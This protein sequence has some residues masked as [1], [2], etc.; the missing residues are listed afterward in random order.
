MPLLQL[1][2]AIIVLS[3]AG[4]YHVPVQNTRGGGREETGIAERRDD[5]GGGIVGL[6]RMKMK[7][8]KVGV[9]VLE[10]LASARKKRL[11][12]ARGPRPSQE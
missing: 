8:G 7:G 3:V 2:C 4:R 11:V 9:S 12:I 5:P 10:L 6:A 1:I